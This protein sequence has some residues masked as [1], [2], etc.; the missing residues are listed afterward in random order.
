MAKECVVVGSGIMGLCSAYFLQ[1]NGF[2][3]R[4][5]EA[6][7]PASGAATGNAGLVAPSHIIPLAAPGVVWQGIKWMFNRE[8]PF[9]IKPRLDLELLGWLYRFWRSS[10]QSHVD[11]ASPVLRDLC[12]KSKILFAEMADSGLDFHVAHPGLVMVCGSAHSLEEELKVAEKARGLGLQAYE[13]SLSQLEP[14]VDWRAKGGVFF[15]GDDV[16][17]PGRFCVALEKALRKRGVVF[18]QE[19]VISLKRVQSR[20]QIQLESG[21][22]TS[23]EHILLTAGAHSSQILRGLGLN[24]PLQPG[25]GYSQTHDQPPMQLKHPLILVEGRV[26]ITPFDSRLR[27]AGTMELAG[28]E[29]K[30]QDRRIQGIHK[31]CQAF[32]GNWNPAMW[33][34]V[35][36]WSG[37]R[38]CTPDGL[39]YVGPLP[40]AS[41]VWVNYGHAMLGLTLGPVCGQLVAES[42]AGN[43]VPYPHLF[44]GRFG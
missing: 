13:V 39:P 22:T 32:I 29:T 11:S 27:V 18:E 15:P 26:A 17:D 14:D 20:H 10:N 41:D 33:S 12:L 24:L 36:V 28:F 16:V 44:P 8:S 1:E 35:P 30:I 2:Q 21:K 5:L 43:A 34:E 3:V 38:P 23:S 40:G 6:E 7:K 31:S 9:Y 25:R 4:I 19:K 37:L 42:M